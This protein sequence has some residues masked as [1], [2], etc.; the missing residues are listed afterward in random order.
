M[1]GTQFSARFSLGLCSARLNRAGLG[2]AGQA[3]I[4]AVGEHRRQD[5]TAIGCLECRWVPVSM[6]VVR[7]AVSVTTSPQAT[8][9]P[10]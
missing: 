6:S 1:D 3:G 8:S 4:V 10:T 2:H 5:D 7:K 9:A